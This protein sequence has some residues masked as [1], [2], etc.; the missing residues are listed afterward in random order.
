VS[1]L[2]PESERDGEWVVVAAFSGLAA[3]IVPEEAIAGLLEHPGG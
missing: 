1:V 3:Q 2:N